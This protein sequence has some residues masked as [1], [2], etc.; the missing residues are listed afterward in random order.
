MTEPWKVIICA[1]SACFF[2]SV[3]EHGVV[4][5]EF[6]IYP[7]IDTEELVEFTCPRCEKVETWGPTR[8]QVA[9]TLYE[10]INNG[11]MD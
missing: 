8:C 1:S 11:G 3:D 6:K 7:E 10:R 5:E 9:K 2:Q 4:R